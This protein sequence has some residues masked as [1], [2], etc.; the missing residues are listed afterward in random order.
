MCSEGM[1]SKNKL[2]PDKRTFIL[3]HA[4]G[5]RQAYLKVDITGFVV[6][7][8]NHYETRPE[9]SPG[10]QDSRVEAGGVDVFSTIEAPRSPA[11]AGRGISIL[12]VE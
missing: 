7:L 2:A 11:E 5:K 4:Q 8:S 1:I 3:R 6:R 10:S 12:R 9:Q